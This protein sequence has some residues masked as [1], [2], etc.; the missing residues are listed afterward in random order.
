MYLVACCSPA[1]AVC[2][3]VQ[4]TAERAA[5]RQAVGNLQRRICEGRWG[6]CVVQAKGSE[7]TEEARVYVHSKSRRSIGEEQTE[8]SKPRNASSE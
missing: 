8:G 6:S 4:Q 5:G 3:E 1:D 2:G 7:G